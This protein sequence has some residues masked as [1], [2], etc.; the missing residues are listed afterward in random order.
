MVRLRTSPTWIIVLP[1]WRCW[2]TSVAFAS[3]SLAKYTSTLK[4]SPS[5]ATFPVPMP[6]NSD[7]TRMV[8]R[9]FST[10]Q[11]RHTNMDD[12]TMLSIISSCF[13]HF[14]F[15]HL[16]SVRWCCWFSVRKSI[17][18]VNIEVMAWLSVWSEVQ[19][20]CICSS[21]CHSHHIISCFTIFVSA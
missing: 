10:C 5:S 6:S 12:T 21:W 7:N 19:M 20:I 2:E 11:P 9:H 18:P 16:P 14:P 13:L 4:P 3:I 15:T 1:W 17:H 8:G